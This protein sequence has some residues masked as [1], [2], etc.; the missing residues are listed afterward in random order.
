MTEWKTPDSYGYVIEVD[1]ER[2]YDGD[3]LRCDI[4]LGCWTWI[5]NESIRLLGI[6]AP[7]RRGKTKEDGLQA[8][9]F[10]Q[11]LVTTYGEPKVGSGSQVI[12]RLMVYTQKDKAGK[13]GR[14]LGVLW[15]D[16]GNGNRVNL[17]EKMI[18]GGH[19]VHYG[20]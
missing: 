6:N 9:A 18:D 17:N 8:R 5:K 14:L 2:I 3:T 19:A 4:D 10:L 16:D 1:P 15:G 12:Y 11:E 20:A 7:E 13:Y